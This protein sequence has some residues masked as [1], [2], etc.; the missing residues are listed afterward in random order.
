MDKLYCN[1]V[2]DSDYNRY[3]QA[4]KCH[5]DCKFADSHYNRYGQDV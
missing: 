4:V 3:E 2:V 5:E 1:N